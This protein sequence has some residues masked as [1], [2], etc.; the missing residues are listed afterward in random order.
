MPGAEVDDR[1]HSDKVRSDDEGCS[2]E[3]H[4]L[5]TPGVV[6]APTQEA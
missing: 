3:A 6:G 5:H 1:N 2:D 4:T